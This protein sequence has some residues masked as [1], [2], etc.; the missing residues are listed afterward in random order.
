MR[1]LFDGSHVLVIPFS[2]T[3]TSPQHVMASVERKLREAS[4]YNMAGVAPT[5]LKAVD[6]AVTL[7]DCEIFTYNPGEFNLHSGCKFCL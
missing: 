4:P 5:L 6:E 3:Y 2:V 7:K 1:F